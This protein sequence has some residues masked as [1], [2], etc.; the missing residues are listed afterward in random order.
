MAEEAPWL[1]GVGRRTGRLSR[2]LLASALMASA[3]LLPGPSAAETAAPGIGRD[4][5]DARVGACADGSAGAGGGGAVA[6]PDLIVDLFPNPSAAAS[7]QAP[8]GDAGQAPAAGPPPS[9][10]AGRPLAEPPRA[11]SGDFVPDEVLVTVDGGPAVVEQV[12][13]AFGLEV[14][15]QRQSALLGATVARLGIPDGRTVGTVLAQLAADGRTGRRE[16]N[17]VFTLQQAAGAVSYA[18]QRIAL[19]A[20]SADGSD[21]RIGVIDTGVDDTHPALKGVVAAAFDA[22]PEVATEGRDH[23]TSIDGLIAGVGP[24][25]GVAPGAAIYHAR[26]FEN[27]KSTMDVILAALD[28]AAGQDVR[29]VNMSFVGPRNELMGIA[30]RNARERGMVLIAAAGNNGPGAPYGYPAAF[31]GVLAVTAT[32]SADALMERANRGAY[33]W[34]AAPGVDLV[35]PIGGG[36]DLVTGTSFA[37]AV[38]SGAVATLLH[39][40][41]GL[42]ADDVERALAAAATDLGPPGRDDDFGY[43][44]L[45]VKAAA[46]AR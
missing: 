9:A 4:C 26:A 38:V 28:W 18:F 10:P 37:A 43:G 33:V 7:P 25:R 8:G 31:P 35:A 23:G 39:A 14:R 27:G 11:I 19:D 17:S 1:C 5:R 46:A 45:N 24:L 6:L 40:D 20:G 22:M 30:C 3:A 13:A 12:A 2:L 44:L 34:I 21:V 29:I 32:D 42:K 15:A 16:P 41:P 36:Q